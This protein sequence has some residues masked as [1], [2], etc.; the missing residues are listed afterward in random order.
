MWALIV[1][2]LLAAVWAFDWG[3]FSDDITL[4][5]AYCNDQNVAFEK[6]ENLI[7]LSSTTYT[8][9][10]QRAEAVYW[11]GGEEFGDLRKLVNCTILDRK[12][13]RCSYPDNQ[14]EKST[15]TWRSRIATH[16]VSGTSS[17]MASMTFMTTQASLACGGVLAARAVALSR[18]LLMWRAERAS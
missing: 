13:W 3:P 6:C 15:N 11:L 7:S 16:R 10:R 9:D 14:R 8:L 18:G 5:S 2:A 12:S 4:Y 1:F 17:R